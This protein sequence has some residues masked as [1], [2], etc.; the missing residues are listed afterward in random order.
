MGFCLLYLAVELLH[1]RI[2]GGAALGG[3][4]A[5]GHVVVR[6]VGVEVVIQVHAVNVVAAHHIHDDPEHVPPRLLARGIEHGGAAC[7]EQPARL[8]AGDM[9]AAHR[10]AA[11]R[12]AE[13]VE[14]GVDFNTAAVR[15][16]DGE[17]QRVIPRVGTRAAQ[18]GA[19]GFN[20]GFVKGISIRTHLQDDGIEAQPGS[21]FDDAEQLGL[22]LA[23]GQSG[24][25]GP[26]QIKYGGYPGS[27][28]LAG[29]FGGVFVHLL[30]GLGQCSSG[31]HENE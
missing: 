5:I 19:P 7:F 2:N 14:P 31:K 28:E 6:R 23:G 22:L 16:G 27:A 20:V 8:A 12:G 29:G 13:G 4:A 15:L 21:L 26:V 25:A 1:E 30:P 24:L 9:A 11:H 17:G 10:A 3:G 18:P